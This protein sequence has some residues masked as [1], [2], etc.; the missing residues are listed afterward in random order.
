VPFRRGVHLVRGAPPSPYQP[1]LAACLAGAP[2]TVASHHAAAWLWGSTQVLPGQLEVTTTLAATRAL[3]GVRTHTTA[4]LL[5]GDVTVRHGVPV[6]SPARTAV[7]VAPC[8]TPYLLAKFV[9]HLRRRRLATY[10]DIDRHLDALGG[11]GRPG[12]RVLRAVLA[13][14]LEGLD[15]GDSDAEVHVVRTLVRHGVPRPEQNAQVLA[16]PKVYVLDL[17]WPRWNIAVEL[18]GFDPHG[19]LRSTFDH[20]KERDLRLR[21]AGWEVIHVSTRTDLRLLAAYLL[22]RMS[23]SE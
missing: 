6:T 13:P 18:D 4:K 2:C 9:D 15:A 22:E 12:T 17:A 23:T 8:L 11:R 10:P 19:I 5:P 14:R 7:D 20:D 16:G 1:I 3:Q 21:R